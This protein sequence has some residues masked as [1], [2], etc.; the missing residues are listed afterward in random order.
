MK[1]DNRRG[2]YFEVTKSLILNN[3]LVGFAK[4]DTT[5]KQGHANSISATVSLWH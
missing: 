4:N 5:E 1:T 3:R 2:N